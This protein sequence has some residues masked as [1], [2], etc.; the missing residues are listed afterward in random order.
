MTILGHGATLLKMT[1]NEP[2]K[3]NK[4]TKVKTH[5]VVTYFASSDQI[6]MST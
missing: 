6:R 5:V 2:K 1:K 3:R 4:M